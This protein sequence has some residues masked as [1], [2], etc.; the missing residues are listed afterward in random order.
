MGLA[1][2]FN[3]YRAGPLL[4]LRPCPRGHFQ[5]FEIRQN[6]YQWIKEGENRKNL[7]LSTQ[8]CVR[9]RCTSDLFITSRTAPRKAVT[10]SGV[11]VFYGLTPDSNIL[12]FITHFDILYYILYILCVRMSVCA[13]GMCV[14]E[15]I[16]GMYE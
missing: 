13:C 4:D 12:S 6:V 1:M 11:C 5:S 2:T 3:P 16:C 14:S 7:M 9:A 8:N 10:A 15:S